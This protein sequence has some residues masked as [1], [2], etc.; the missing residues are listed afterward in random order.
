MLKSTF[1][2]F[3]SISTSID[4]ETERHAEMLQELDD[5]LKIKNQA[6]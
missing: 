4:Q 2:Q 1:S 5:D 3:E 6:F